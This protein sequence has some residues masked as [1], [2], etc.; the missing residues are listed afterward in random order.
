MDP[1]VLC[2]LLQID[3]FRMKCWDGFRGFDQVDENFSIKDGVDALMKTTQLDEADLVCTPGCLPSVVSN[4]FIVW[5]QIPSRPCASTQKIPASG[6]NHARDLS[7]CSLC[8]FEDQTLPVLAYVL[9]SVFAENLERSVC[10][11]VQR[12]HGQAL[13]AGHGVGGL[14]WGPR[15]G[16]RRVQTDCQYPVRKGRTRYV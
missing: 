13:T 8:A 15:I 4:R 12:H 14:L 9:P 5:I 16:G 6:P 7:V 3:T 1:W 2:A 10:G 11:S